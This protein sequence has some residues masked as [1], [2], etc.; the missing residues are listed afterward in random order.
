MDADLGACPWQIGPFDLFSG[1]APCRTVVWVLISGLALC[2][3]TQFPPSSSAMALRSVAAAISESNLDLNSVL[4]ED[5]V[6]ALIKYFADL[7]VIRMC[8]MRVSFC[9]E[10]LD[11]DLDEIADDIDDTLKVQIVAVAKPVMEKALGLSPSSGLSVIARGE[12]APKRWLNGTWVDRNP[13]QQLLGAAQIVPVSS[14]SSLSTA[15]MSSCYKRTPS[16]PPLPLAKVHRVADDLSS[17][18]CPDVET[19]CDK[20]SVVVRNRPTLSD[21]R[22]K[23]M[24]ALKSECVRLW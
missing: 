9:A 6:V 13:V 16:F 22:E 17:S 4:P 2:R 24:T 19:R 18:I 15:C 12:F 1:L 20:P 14:S 11:E 23:A 5:V 21:K 3:S 10:Q 7:K 8:D